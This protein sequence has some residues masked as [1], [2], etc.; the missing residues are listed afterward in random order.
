MTTDKI[1]GIIYGSF[2]GDAIALGPHWIYNTEEIKTHFHPITGF[3]TP[4]HTPYHQG[5]EAGDFTHYGDQSLLLL[6]SLSTNQDFNVDEFKHDWLHFMTHENLYLD[7]ASKT[8]IQLLSDANTF[9]GSESDELG[10]FARSAPLFALQQSGHE[11]FIK[12]TALT[13]NNPLLFKISDYFIDVIYDVATGIDIKEALK[14]QLE[15]RD[16]FIIA[17]Y[18]NALAQ[19]GTIV[20]AV[21][22]IGQSCS[23]NFGL[24]SVVSIL[25]K[26][27]TKDCDFKEILINN[28]YAGGDSA[29][30]GMILGMILGAK[31]GYQN[32]PQD[33]LRGLNKEHE[34]HDYLVG[35]KLNHIYANS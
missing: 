12:Q 16:P 33:L 23:S 10:G 28:V 7:H 21:G 9:T 11:A 24:P 18:E 22:T 3:S 32:I 15:G 34:I 13:H 31:V 27:D 2:I 1:L 8:S 26:S 19:S 17:S 29:S 4:S 20:E 30:R 35:L 6:K 14:A 25:L 5:K